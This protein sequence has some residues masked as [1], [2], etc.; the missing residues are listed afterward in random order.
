M[1]IKDNV[2]VVDDE[3]SPCKPE[4]LAKGLRSWESSIRP[5][6]YVFTPD[7]PDVHSIPCL[8]ACRPEQHVGQ[9]SDRNLEVE[10]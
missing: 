4:S 10:G 5:P 1:N 9:S 3:T 8:S 2:V 7:F 6:V